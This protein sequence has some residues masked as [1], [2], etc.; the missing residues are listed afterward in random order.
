MKSNNI[1]TV[2]VI[3]GATGNLI[4]EKIAPALFYLFKENKL[5]DKL[6]VVGFSRQKLS[7]EAYSGRVMDMLAKHNFTDTKM[8][9][10]F[11][12]LFSYQAGDFATQ[13]DYVELAK[14]LKKID[15][16]WGVC[17]NKLFYLAVPPIFYEIILNNLADSGLTIPCSVEEGWS[18]VIVEKPFGNNLETAKSLDM[19]LGSLFKEEQIYRIDHYLGKEMIQNVLSFRFSNNIFEQIWDKNSIE[20]IEIF[21]N[22]TI[23]VEERGSFYDNVGALQDV[24]QNHLLQMLALL[25]MEKPLTL[26]SDEIRKRRADILKTL[27]PLS[28]DDI[29]AQTYRA[30]YQGYKEIKGVKPES[31]RETYFKIKLSLSSHHFLGVPIIIESGKRLHTLK[32]GVEISFRHQ[33]PSFYPK[34]EQGRYT[35]KI[36]ITLEPE[37]SIKIDFWAKKPGSKFEMEMKTFDFMFDYKKFSG[38]HVEEYKNLL[39]D[40]I[41][42]D[43]TLFV[44]TDELFAAWN[45]IDPI[46]NAW[47]ENVVPL[48]TYKI[49]TDEPTIDSAYIENPPVIESDI[50]LEK[51]IGIIGL[52]KMGGGIARHLHERNWKVV[53]Y[54]RTAEVTKE[55]VAEGMTGIYEIK[56]F[57]KELSAPRIIWLMVP[58]GKVGDEIIFGKDGLVNIL[59]RGDY[60]I[61]GGNS[62]YTDT[63]QRAEKISEY[64]INFMDVGTSGGPSGARNGA[65]LMIGGKRKDFERLEPLFIDMSVKDGYQFFEGAG[66]GH[67]VKMIH[68]GIEYGMMQAIA[69]GF[70]ILKKSHYNINLKDVS[71]IYNNGSVI[72]S[73]LTEWLLK[74]FILHGED[75]DGV[76]GSVAH[77]GEGEWTVKAA[78]ELN[79]KAKIIE[80]SLEFR[81]KSEKN[82]SFAGKV[83]S[84]LREQFGGHSIKG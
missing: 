2:F 84:A 29:Q 14:A 74:A 69:E 39:L 4:E 56:D 57:L 62:H 80:E 48:H 23:G 75:L 81:I 34:E 11:C 61:D 73:R 20:K 28:I 46:I 50:N 45:F 58:A 43:Q 52:G 49:G 5:P 33:L 66:A 37:E 15:D 6:K 42:G 67:F 79:V 36:S 19:I 77:T 83:L 31:Q 25:T 18:R 78:K 3:F 70:E 12:K 24:G 16:A 44:S 7:D 51:E 26:S 1:P 30:Q 55:F 54:N 10:D 8:C 22:E 21:L 59:D 40:V 82:P 64:G 53:G 68:N 60:I 41:A 9:T 17:T 47:K 76:S 63:I 65:C 35:N 32:K 38:Q 13:A 27:I 71:E 72:E